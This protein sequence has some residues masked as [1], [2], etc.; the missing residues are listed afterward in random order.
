[1]KRRPIPA[2]G[3]VGEAALREAAATEFGQVRDLLQAALR[4]NYGLGENDWV[5][6][7][8]LYPDRVVVQRDGKNY[9]FAYTIDDANAVTL[10]TA[11]EV[12]M[13]TTPVDTTVREA[14]ATEQRAV[15]ALVMAAI[16][17]VKPDVWDL[18]AMYPDRVVIADNDRRQYAYP[19]TIDDNNQVTLGTPYE[20][21]SQHVPASS[22]VP[23]REAKN[24]DPP[25]SG[26]AA[27]DLQGAVFIEALQA[28]EGQKP[29]RYLVRVIKAG[30]SLNNVTYPRDVL[31][32][33]TP[34]FN[35][36]RVFVKS[37]AEH[38]KGGGKDVRQLV[39]RL[40]DAK[41]VE[42]G[43]GEIQAVLDV[44]ES[45]EVAPML[46]E[47]VE[48]GMTDLFGLSIDASGKSKQTGKFREATKLTKVAS[49]DLIIE[50]GAGG[51]LIRFVEAHHEEDTMLRSQ[52]IK[53]I[54]ARD[55]KRAEGL[56]NASD[57]DV[58][59]AYREA[60][61]TPASGDR[62]TGGITQEQLIEHTRMIE[63]RA[64]AR[65]A[66]AESKLPLPTQM[67][68]NEHFREAASFTAADVEAA[69][70]SEREYLGKIVDGAK[71]TGLGQF[72]EAGDGRAEKMAAML[73]DFFDP[74]KR[75]MSFRECYVELT[76]DRQVT[77]LMQN[78]DVDRLREAAGG[79]KFREAV[80][81]ATFSNILG[82]SITRAMIREYGALESYKDW[83]WMCD[84]VP[85]TDF[86]T[87][88]RTRLGGYGNLPAVA[89]NGA[90]AALTSPGDE[91]AS[92]AV[93]KRGGTETISMETIANDDVGLLRR[94]PRALATAAGRTLYEFVYAFLD[95]NAAIYDTVALFHASHN[96]LGTAALDA[97]SIAAARLA[98]K[99][100]TE[101]TS[102]KRLGITMR[103]L[104]IPSDLEEAAYN[105][106]QRGTNND[107]TFVQSRVPTVH[108]V[109]H[110]TDANNWYAAADNASVPLIEMG[111][112]GSQDPE[113]FVQDLPTQGS[114]FSND[115]I[116]YKIRHIYS[117]AVRDYRGFYGAIVA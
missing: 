19:Y 45:A 62:S 6:I 42:A 79:D 95:S 101:L 43:V 93:T 12:V 86:R 111:F 41:F 106:F 75:A 51:Q 7:Q 53:E 47:A 110:W 103:H 59:V 28:P 36:A 94:I 29:S 109:D 78:V 44:F 33:A 21:V 96:N 97:T 88:E 108:V 50:P 81:A 57:D 10:G 112:Y 102:T 34:L 70:K 113:L 98:M 87:Q 100:Q 58:L 69:I 37:D 2:A 68:L 55:A 18:I 20:V 63:A 30:T 8:A 99:K 76:G 14:A 84:I 72:I 15:N 91:A 13:T 116:K 38:I 32:E 22:A 105:L 73:D 17:K 82:D 65:V 24:N 3:I 71:V 31:R 107:A 64:D 61:G 90:Y 115:Q 117:G 40:S 114:L 1:M 11:Q 46:R 60:V 27:G 23:V 104:V 67:R 77:G 5:C 89:E 85:V 25:E 83:Q 26:K 54:G 80:S 16:R 66:I 9:E 92:Y 4:R 74:T 49:V 39:G 56:A 52:M 35:G 48:R